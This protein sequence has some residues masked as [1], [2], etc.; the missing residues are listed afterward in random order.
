MPELVPEL[1][2]EIR[3][4][5]SEHGTFT[6][7]A[8]QQMKKL[9]S[10]LREVT[11]LWPQ[12]FSSFS[13]KVLKP[14][15]LSNGQVI[16]AGVVIEVPSHSMMNDPGVFENA[17]EFD[18]FRSYRA[19]EKG[20]LGGAEKAGVGAASQLVSINTSNLTFG[21]GRH[22]CPGRFF[23]ANE[24]KMILGR[25]LLDYDIKTADGATE[26]YPNL[27]FQNSVS[28]AYYY[29]YLILSLLRL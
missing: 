22:A 13:R 26:R 21:Y 12:T 4:V 5:L 23:A 10:F 24:L 7:A 1:R 14:I 20:G 18:A 28:S 17:H 16:P 11:R 6:S 25:A 2:E 19:R 29:Y 8:L 3:T 27:A 15:T 9:D